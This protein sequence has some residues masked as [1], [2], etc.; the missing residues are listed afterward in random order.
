[1]EIS[2]K[3]CPSDRTCVFGF[4]KVLQKATATVDYCEGCWIK[5]Q[6]DNCTTEIRIFDEN[7]NHHIDVKF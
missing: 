5:G 2:W 1:M 7:E 6:G 4:R 3:M